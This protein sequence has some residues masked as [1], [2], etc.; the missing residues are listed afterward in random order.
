ME[1]I[2][3]MDWDMKLNA[4]FSKWFNP[5]EGNVQDEILATLSLLRELRL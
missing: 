1:D 3:P 2:A 4:K 5:L